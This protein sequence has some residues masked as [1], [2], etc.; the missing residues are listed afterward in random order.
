MATSYSVF[1]KMHTQGA[2]Q[3]SNDIKK[4]ET[5]SKSASLAAGGLSKTLGMLAGALAVGKV[6]AANDAWI[7]YA[8]TLKATGLAG[9]E[10]LET[11]KDLFDMAQQTG[12]GIS[13]TADIYRALKTTIGEAGASQ[14]D[15][16]KVTRALNE[17]IIQSGASAQQAQGGIIQ[18]SQVFEKGKLQ[19][20][21]YNSIV[22]DFPAIGNLLRQAFLQA[23]G[24]TETFRQQMEDGK[25]TA[26]S[27]F[28]ALKLVSPKLDE[29]QI[30][31]QETA[32]QGVTKLENSFDKLVGT[33]SEVLHTNSI[34]QKAFDTLSEQI[35]GVSSAVS[36]LNKT[37]NNSNSGFV[38]YLKSIA[39][40]VLET[41]PV[42]VM[43]GGLKKD[44]EGYIDSID[45]AS[46]SNEKMAE[47]LK[48][49]TNISP[50]VSKL[51][52]I[53]NFLGRNTVSVNEFN[54][55]L[56][57]IGTDFSGAGLDKL[58]KDLAQ[59]A[60]SMNDF[61]AKAT[62]FGR[63][64]NSVN[65][66]GVPSI[67]E[68]IFGQSQ[69]QSIVRY[70]NLVKEAQQEIIKT[71]E[72]AP[73][74][75][76][77]ITVK[78]DQ[79]R[80]WNSLKS[81]VDTVGGDISSSFGSAV[82][83]IVTGSQSASEAFKQMANSII[84]DLIK[85]GI[86]RAILGTIS[87][88][89]SGFSTGG[90]ATN[91]SQKFASGGHVSGAGTSTSDSIPAMLSD[92]EFVMRA[93]AVRSIGVNNLSRLNSGGV[94]AMGVSNLNT[95][96]SQQNT[97]NINTTVNSPSARSGSGGNVNDNQR[98]SSE[99]AKL[100]A[101]LVNTQVKQELVKQTRVG[102]ILHMGSK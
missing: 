77:A 12:V 98:Q 69:A 20:Q 83:S 71:G 7:T 59:G 75:M 67:G 51:S 46:S 29:T 85:I 31:M 93:S 62:D 26:Q 24:G 54:K 64:M 42:G 38:D 16:L 97:I 15:L 99:Q 102:G 91:T 14:E 73:A 92:G 74:T 55:S 101:N 82:A 44:I 1:I 4:V 11:Q 58:K 18:L 28:D 17:G 49:I 47:S 41:S 79:I 36:G 21:E 30:S 90:L 89:S 66:S 22:S 57:S 48:E 34:L 70:K 5:S 32:E 3:T 37:M 100:I 8:N 96:K 35:D 84:S 40:F 6:V 80:S 60:D 65:F 9:D 43:F 81:I 86:E 94:S 19:A 33:G 61:K 88:I 72:V 27:F 50:I 45:T 76:E 56:E 63:V 95:F 39:K 52:N 25:I 68:S 87:A 13:E 2:S 10:L 78:G 23:S 53:D